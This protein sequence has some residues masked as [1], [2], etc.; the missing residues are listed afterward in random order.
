VYVCVSVDLICSASLCKC[1]CGVGDGD[2]GHE[3]QNSIVIQ[4]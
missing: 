1:V 4:A 3:A 2:E